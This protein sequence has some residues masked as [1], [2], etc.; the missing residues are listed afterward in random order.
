MSLGT[1]PGQRVR[2]I[3]FW[4]AVALVM[5]NMIGSGVFL[6]PSS[7]ANY[8]GLS[9][10]GWCISAGGSMMLALVFARLARL[11]P[12]AGGIYAYTRSAFG[13]VAGFLVA[14]GY[15]LS[16]IAT[17][18][19]LAVAFVGYL[20]P[21]APELVRRPSRAAAL[22]IATIWLLAGVN[23]RGLRGAGRLQIA[24]TLLKILPLAAVGLAGLVVLKPSH[25]AIP[26][27]HLA[28]AKS[29]GGAIAGVMT[30]TLWAFLGLESATIPAASV[31]HPERTIPRATVAGTAIAALIYMVSTAGVM[32]AIDPQSLGSSTAPFADAARVL[33]GHGAA[34][35]VAAGAAISCFGALNG[36][37]LLAGHFPLAVADDGLFPR[38]FSRLSRRALPVPG[39]LFGATLASLLVAANYTRGLVA[40]FTFFILLATLSTLV[41]YT[42][43]SLA[44][45]LTG[46][47]AD[48]RGAMPRL[49]ISIVATL[50]FLYSLAAIGGAGADTVYWGF[51]LLVAGLPVYVWVKRQHRE[52]ETLSSCDEVGLLERVAV[53]TARDAFLDMDAIAAQWRDLG[54][55]APPDSGRAIGESERFLALLESAGA[56]L[57]RLP[58]GRGVGLDSIYVRD[59]SVVT[60]RGMV[61]C[62]MGKPQRRGEPAA[63]AESFREWGIQVAGEIREPGHLEGGDLVWLD[64]ATVAVGRGYRTDDQGIRQL[65]AIL[66]D[67]VEV[68]VVP[69]VHWRGAGDVFHL[70]SI[71]SPVDR[72]LAV[73]YAPLLPV[74]FR[75]LLLARG[76]ELVEV[77]DQEFDTMGANVLSVAPRR[78]VMLEGNPET[79][80]RLESAG[81]EV[82]TYEGN[83]ISLKGGGGPTCLTRPL[84]RRA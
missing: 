45:F 2:V 81:V 32:G 22:A 84:S 74:P 19:A 80:S 69:L 53:K 70:M 12:K 39:L 38:L 56:E 60:P 9:L 4:T 7:L 57:L 10:V 20:D 6:L 44:V 65:R 26:A 62:N 55:T 75:E 71:V 16:I 54:F 51:L 61:L 17:L 79:R 59:A 33:F 50:A 3:G 72:D 46:D 68:I 58:A 78:C 13:D 76:I 49:G 67:D 27:Q 41:P 8:G 82:L 21:F 11:N 1:S 28:S 30:L 52:S 15:W 24:T 31:R 42:F 29:L 36:W 77:P 5:G 18:A 25:F 43:C 73:V 37:T 34:L 64:G 40:L 63:Q 14:W 66:G 47:P 83:E 23:A 35:A 48:R